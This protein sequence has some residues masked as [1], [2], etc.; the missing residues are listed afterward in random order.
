MRSF[1]GLFLLSQPWGT[2]G[3]FNSAGN[4]METVGF[5]LLYSVIVALVS[6]IVFCIAKL[7]STP[8]DSG[9][10]WRGTATDIDDAATDPAYSYD[11]G[12]IFHHRED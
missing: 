1:F 9:P 5:L 10:K 11:I 6:L 4:I 2:G 7:S 12:N 3:N 8:I